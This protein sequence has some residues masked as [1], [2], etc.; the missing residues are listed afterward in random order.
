MKLEYTSPTTHA[1][2]HGSSLELVISS[3][4]VT[5]MIIRRVTSPARLPGDT[6]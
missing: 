4:A 2:W 3:A 1:G 5:T 6:H